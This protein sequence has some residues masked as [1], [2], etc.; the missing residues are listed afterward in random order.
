MTDDRLAIIASCIHKIE[1][2]MFDA[3]KVTVNGLNSL[4]T[5]INNRSTMVS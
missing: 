3:S 1:F 2:L 4:T 5:A